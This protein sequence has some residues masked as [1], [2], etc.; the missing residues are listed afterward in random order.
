MKV[1]PARI[2]M[3]PII[4]REKMKLTEISKKLSASKINYSKA[5]MVNNGIQ[6][7]PSSEH[8]YRN[9]YEILKNE[10]IEF[11]TFELKTKNSTRNHGQKIYTNDPG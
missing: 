1:E 7:E 9:M 11:H 10:K 3:A 4:I 2:K 8:D 5:K 6:I